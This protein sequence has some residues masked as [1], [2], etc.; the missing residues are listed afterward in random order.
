MLDILSSGFKKA[1][2]KLRGK[3]TLSED[4]LAEAMTDVRQSLLEADVEYSVA[5][6][7]IKNVKDKALGDTVSLKAGSG[8]NRRTV[9]PGDHFVS[10][11]KDELENL[12]GMG[13][14]GF[15]LPSQR[16]A[17]VMLVGLQGTGKTTTCA[18]LAKYLGERKHR[19]PLLVAADIYRPAAVHQL[20]V[21]GQKLSMP[22]FHIE[23]L[24]P[25]EICQKAETK[26][27]ELGCDVII[28]DTAGR[29]SIDHDLMQELLAIKSATSPDHILL[30]CDAMMGQDAVTTA[31]SFNELLDLSGFIMT[32]LDGDARGGAAL[33][34]REVTG[35]PIKF[36]GVGESL[37]RLEVFRPDGLASRI[38]GMGDVVGLMDDF[39]RV[40]EGDKDA[41]A[42]RMLQGRFNFN[43]FYEQIATIQKMGS[44][45]EV[46]AKLPMQNLIPKDAKVDDGELVK[47]KSMIDSMTK[48]ERLIPDLVNPSRA[49]RIAM[50]SGRS[51]KEVSDLVQ[52]FKG[53]RKLMGSLGKNMGGLMGRI[54]GM[55]ALSQMRQ[56]KKMAGQ[57]LP[58]LADN[59]GISGQSML[60]KRVDRDKVKKARRAAKNS[61]KKNRKK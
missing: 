6:N 51:L 5:K 38:L 32:K 21:L 3:A 43:D 49:R 27:A 56:L 41:D 35:K 50:G 12:M 44:L 18:K 55:N 24:A 7:F 34:I 26:A 28:F 45:K 1:S 9:N 46:V 39:E 31:K 13:E 16:L 54:P 4:N 52:K 59:F 14:S 40:S 36:L 19:K 20:K 53:M 60:T 29:L 48:K 25:P 2:E 17:K 61:R 15:K 37:E 57:G 58:S 11:C 47:V 30:V 10:I 8:A 42:L 23:G 33:S 22:V